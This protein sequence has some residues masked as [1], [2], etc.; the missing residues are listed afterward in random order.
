LVKHPVGSIVVTAPSVMCALYGALV[1]S[2]MPTALVG[3]RVPS[4]L[5]QRMKIAALIGGAVAGFDASSSFFLYPAVR[6]SIANGNASAASWFLTISGIVGAAVLL[7]AGR[8]AD[9]YGHHRLFVVGATGFAV[10]TLLA[11]VAPT[12]PLLIAARALQAAA[13][14]VIGP[15]SVAI[16]VAVSAPERRAAD[17]GLFAAATGA[18]GMFG[19]VVT[20]LLIKATSWRIPMLVMIPI[21]VVGMVFAWPGWSVE[22]AA[23]RASVPLD[24][25]GG[26]AVMTGL[27]L[28]VAAVVKGNAWG[29]LSARAITL[30]VVAVLLLVAAVW[31]ARH[32][33]D[34]A[35]PLDL[36]PFRSLRVGAALGFVASFAFF[37][38]WLALMGYMTGVW[39]YS[40]TRAGMWLTL[41]PAMMM[42]FGVAAGKAA[43]RVGF[44]RV[45]V[46][47]AVFYAIGFG[48]FALR[49][50]ATPNR[51][52]LFLGVFAA[53]VGMAGV[54]PLLASVGTRGLPPDRMATGAALLQ[55][56][57]RMGGSLGS[58]AVVVLLE[59][60][61]AGVARH[62]RPMWM[63]AASGLLIA[64]IAGVF[65]TEGLR[66][67]ST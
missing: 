31:R 65:A 23:E 43:D 29:W 30:L 1:T 55:T 47:S 38:H 35:V 24:I 64:L 56:V 21:I 62:M 60:S 10:A 37:A 61:G 19:P 36:F 46:P 48:V 51:L 34:P 58:A 5:Q 50:T 4:P 16:I 49:A 32:H 11:V 44:R 2:S 17:L 15:S 9:R 13:L 14:A 33:A 27:G 53:G 54:W 63:L 57:Q 6:D 59:G 7:Q 45:L 8:L 3:V 20:A 12:L 40:A 28:L 42:M 26:L 39:K 52:M 67:P 25:V 22:R 66:S 41:M 18:M